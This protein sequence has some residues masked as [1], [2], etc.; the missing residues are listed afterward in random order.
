MNRR[1]DAGPKRGRSIGRRLAMLIALLATAALVAACGSSDDSSTASTDGGTSASGGAPSPATTSASFTQDQKDR[2][3]DLGDKAGDEA[4]KAKLPELTA[5][6]LQIAGAPQSAQR[7]QYSMEQAIKSLGWKSIVCDAQGQPA[8]MA[9][10]GDTLLNRGAKV[11]FSISIEPS[12]LSAQLKRAQKMGVPFVNYPGGVA[13]S[14]LL[15]GSYYT[16]EVKK[17]KLLADYVA[18]KTKDMDAPVEA[19]SETFPPA[20]AMD[21]NKGLVAAADA[22]GSN[23]KIV[24]THVSDGTQLDTDTRQAVTSALTAHPDLKVLWF[25]YDSAVQSAAPVIAA[26]TGNKQFPDGPMVVSFHAEQATQDLVRRGQITAI[27]DANVDALAWVSA[28]QAAQYFARDKPF[29]K[30]FAPEYPID[31]LSYQI[32]TK[33]NLPA[34][35]GWVVP[36][37][38]FVDF[39]KAKWNKEFGLNEGGD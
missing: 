34:K 7:A 1:T 38:D 15:S 37:D 35:G 3:I 22:S 31:Y 14:P 10:C 26:K 19:F 8:E 30:D 16:D 21:R 12:I 32:V 11:I 17:G 36:K 20:W 2:A 23:L 39:F 18:D 13:D 25:N 28:D 4:G 6:I 27:A 9:R 24:D 5:G 29:S 33:D